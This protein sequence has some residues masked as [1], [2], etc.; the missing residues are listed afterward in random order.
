MEGHLRLSFANKA[1]RSPNDLYNVCVTLK[2]KPL[3]QIIRQEEKHYISISYD[4]LLQR[5]E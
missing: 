3:K 4:V 1:E 5:F 2:F